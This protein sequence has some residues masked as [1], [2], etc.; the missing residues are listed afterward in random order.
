MREAGS[1]WVLGPKF[2]HLRVHWSDSMTSILD[3]L[4]REIGRDRDRET[5]RETEGEND[6]DRD[7]GRQK[8]REIER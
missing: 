7:R 4:E 3:P 1:H 2:E 8:Q 6:R 5:E